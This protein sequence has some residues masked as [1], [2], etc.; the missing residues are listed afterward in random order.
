MTDI[1]VKGLLELQ[2][3][4]DQLSPKMEANIMRGALRAGCKPVLEQAKANVPVKS[5]VLR[6]TLRISSSI[7]KQDGKVTASVK[8]GGKYR[9]KDAFYAPW[10]EFTGARPH[11]ITGNLSINGRV[12]SNVNHP[13]MH[14]KP[15]L[16]PALDARANDAVIAAAEYIKN[17]L[18]TREGLNTADI[19]IGIDDEN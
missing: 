1:N 2:A 13:G 18:A 16:R 15:F 10:I 12:F 8:V 4:L 6:D 5:G 14:A 19:N 17:R 7:K 11:S 3:F 9:G